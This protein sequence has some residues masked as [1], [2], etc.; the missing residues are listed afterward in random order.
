M[1]MALADRVRYQREKALYHAT[2]TQQTE[3]LNQAMLKQA[4]MAITSEHRLANLCLVKIEQ[5][6]ALM[7][8]LKPSQS[9][10]IIITVAQSLEH[11]INK[12]RQ[13]INLESALD[14]SPKVADLGNGILAFI[15][16]KISYFW[17]II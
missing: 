17:A 16:T 4:Y 13:F 10:Q 3:L 11:Q 14:N 9:S 2:H 6:N 12:K 1:A 8:I 15:S 5:F 7:S